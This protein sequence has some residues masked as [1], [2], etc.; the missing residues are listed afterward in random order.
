MRFMILFFVMLSLVL[1]GCADYGKYVDAVSAANKEIAA[2]NAASKTATLQ[3][4]SQAMVAAGQ[5]DDSGDDVAVA[6]LFTQQL[7]QG[8][9]PLMPMSAPE[10]MSVVISSLVPIAVAG[11]A[12]ATVASVA[13]NSGGS[14][15]S[16][17]NG[18]KQVDVSGDG[19]TVAQDNPIT[20]TVVTEAAPAE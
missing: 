14:S 16:Y 2:Q 7:A 11:V 6:I 9:T 4:M 19:S 12:G 17:D 13:R 3:A 5:T 8:G 1:G 10:K 18:S 20:E 15:T